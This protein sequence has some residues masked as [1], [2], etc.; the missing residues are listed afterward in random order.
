VQA[1]EHAA[2]ASA[3]P[4][5]GGD[6]RQIVIEGRPEDAAADRVWSVAV[7]PGY[8]ETL[9]IGVVRGR[10]FT[11]G[12]GSPGRESVIVSERLV[13]QYFA[14]ADPVGRRLQLRDGLDAGSREAARAAARPAR[15]HPV[16]R[17]RAGGIATRRPECSRRR[18]PDG[19]A[20]GG[21]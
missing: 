16:P 18:G 17:G 3:L 9:G 10:D 2:L 4:L 15:L 13:E 14:D 6:Q 8:F 21:A 5:S 12:D 11:P 20:Q 19:A 7:G 1:V